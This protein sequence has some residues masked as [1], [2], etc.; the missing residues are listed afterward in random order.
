M[1]VRRPNVDRFPALFANNPAP[2][3]CCVSG[4]AHRGSVSVELSDDTPVWHTIDRGVDGGRRI[5]SRYILL[6]RG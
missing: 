4:H 6:E 1:N 3:N 5:D 2:Q